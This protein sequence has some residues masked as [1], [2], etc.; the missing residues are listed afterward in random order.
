LTVTEDDNWGDS[1]NPFFTA[2]A[3]GASWDSAAGL[4]GIDVAHGGSETNKTEIVADDFGF[5][6]LPAYE[7]TKCGD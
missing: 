7:G 3:T 5:C 2:T 6:A 1:T 4:K